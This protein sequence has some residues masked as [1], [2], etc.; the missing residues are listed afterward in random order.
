MVISQNKVAAITYTLKSNSAEGNII[1]TV[2]STKPVEFIFGQGSL[3]PAFEQYLDGLTS[4]EGF[5][6]V[7]PSNEAYGVFKAELVV[8]LNKDLFSHNGVVNEQILTIGNQIPMMDSAGRRLNGIVKEV[9]EDKVMMDFNHPLAGQDLHFAGKV[10]MVREAT[11]EE[12]NPPAHHGCGCGSGPA[13][14]SCCSTPKHE[15]AHGHNHDDDHGCG[16]GNGSCGC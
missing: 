15:H 13:D 8:E 10:E 4:G 6:F 11:Y 16:C 1:E 9:K 14:E 5:E 3:L 7:I 2:D 12:L